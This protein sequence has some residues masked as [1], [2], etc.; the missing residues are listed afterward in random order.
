MIKNMT[1]KFFTGPSTEIV[2]LMTKNRIL[3]GSPQVTL[4]DMNAH[5][6]VDEDF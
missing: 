5:D 3:D 2:V 4:G 1:K 6:I